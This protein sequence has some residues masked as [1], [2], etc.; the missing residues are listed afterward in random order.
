MTKHQKGK[1]Q[2]RPA[3]ANKPEPHVRKTPQVGDKLAITVK[4]VLDD[5][6]MPTGRYELCESSEIIH[7]S[8]AGVYT[9]GTIKDSLGEKWRVKP[10]SN[11][12]VTT[13]NQRVFYNH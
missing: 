2:V 11:G 3:F 10:T 5:S 6:G 9:D 1:A 13:E 12:W 8:I 4:S 7:R